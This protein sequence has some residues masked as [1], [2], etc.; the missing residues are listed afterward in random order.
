MS[1]DNIQFYFI[2]TSNPAA[3]ANV[4]IDAAVEISADATTMN[5]LDQNIW[6]CDLILSLSS[7]L[8]K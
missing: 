6:P 2:V 4:T 8:L 3:D 7:I 1:H 5:V